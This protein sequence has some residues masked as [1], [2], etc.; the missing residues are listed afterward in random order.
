MTKTSQEL[1]TT[2]KIAI[3]TLHHEMGHTPRFT[4]FSQVSPK[5]NLLK[6]GVLTCFKLLSVVPHPSLFTYFND[7]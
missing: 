3:S 4:S 7:F 6:L 1:K 5:K 2:T